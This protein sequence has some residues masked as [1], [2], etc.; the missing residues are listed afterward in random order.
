MF[1]CVMMR[2]HGPSTLVLESS[3]VTR[4]NSVFRNSLTFLLPSA[5][6]SPMMMKL[7]ACATLIW[8]G[9]HVGRG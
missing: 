5:N 6:A 1:Q 2:F 8:G 7:T 4:L 9:G 3:S